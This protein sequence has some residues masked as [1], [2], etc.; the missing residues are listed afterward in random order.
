[1]TK[2]AELV[3]GVYVI[4]DSENPGVP[5]IDLTNPGGDLIGYNANILRVLWSVVTSDENHLYLAADDRKI[6]FGEDNNAAI[7]YNGNYLIVDPQVV[8]S[9][10]VVITGGAFHKLYDTDLFQDQAYKVGSG[11]ELDGTPHA[12][13]GYTLYHRWGDG[14]YGT[15]GWN[16]VFGTA[17]HPVL[18][19]SNENVGIGTAAGGYPLTVLRPSLGN[20]ASSVVSIMGGGVDGSLGPLNLAFG[21][22]PSATGGLRYG[23]IQCGDSGDLRP[24]SLNSTGGGY[25]GNVGIGTDYPWSRFDVASGAKTTDGASIVTVRTADASP[26]CLLVSTIGSA[27]AGNQGFYIDVTEPGVSDDRPLCFQRYGGNVGI[28]TVRPDC[29]LDVE[30]AGINT[31]AKF[32]ASLPVYM[33][34]SWPT[35]G[36]NSYYGASGWTFG[37][38]SSSNYGG[39]I[40]FDPTSGD[41]IIYSSN[42]TGNAGDALTN[43]ERGRFTSSGVKGT[44]GFVSADGS[45]GITA[46]IPATATLQ[47]KNG[48]IVGY[49]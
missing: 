43:S 48:L 41:F 9:G 10:G 4:T 47:V 29:P 12:S 37:A 6:Y 8:G 35:I 38:G 45:A 44:A 5:L 28:G 34:A 16:M 25:F 2:Q 15:G 46:S 23:Y 40:G 26:V 33:M 22:H 39:S 14:G 3:D 7:Y 21:V 19:F 11:Y 1:M 18:S 27:T 36:F 13:G 30:R 32:G 17:A 20:D 49:S 24:L 42:A 31:F